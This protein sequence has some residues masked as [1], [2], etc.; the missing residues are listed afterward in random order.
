[1]KATSTS[2]PEFAVHVHAADANGFLAN[3][4]LIETP[5]SIVAVDALMRVSD[6]R[7]L[8]AK[9]E[10][11]GKPLAAVLI[12]HGHPD[13]YN[14]V[15]ELLG[16]GKIRVI[17]TPRVDEVIRKCDEAFAARWIP[18]FG[19]DWPRARTF[20]NE[21]VQSGDVLEFDGVPFRV[22]DVGPGESHHDS[23]WIV[24]RTE[25]AA[26]IGDMV[27][28]RVHPFVKDGHT[29]A[30]LRNLKRMGRDLAHVPEIYS[31]HGDALLGPDSFE[32][33]A[34]YLS[35]YR[36]VVSRLARGAASLEAE[37]KAELVRTMKEFLRTDRLLDFAL[38]GADVV[39]KELAEE[40]PRLADS[41]C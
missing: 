18:T 11:I 31:G 25:R 1:M 20:P 30:W 37:A 27:F 35:Q 7:A 33:Q 23:Y 16:L 3:A 38:A 12:T 26:F 41:S 32:E 21:L 40:E 9:C 28:G 14:G 17:A 10:A 8:R 13:H 29:A 15:T 22:E 24:G 36:A 39:A 34:R 2:K 4:F 5:R 6:G 19:D